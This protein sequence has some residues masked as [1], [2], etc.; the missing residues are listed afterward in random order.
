MPSSPN[1]PMMR[2]CEL[3]L[4][5]ISGESYDGKT[6]LVNEGLGV[7]GSWSVSERLLA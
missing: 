7:G 6:P 1:F 4:P 2:E 3:V 5:I